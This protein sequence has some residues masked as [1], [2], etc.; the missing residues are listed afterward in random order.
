MHEYMTEVH[1]FQGLRLIESFF[2]Y[3][4]LHYIYILPM[5]FIFLKYLSMRF[6]VYKFD[7]AKSDL[8]RVLFYLVL[9]I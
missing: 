5:T 7:M 9:T 3:N 4:A 8:L 2:F 1:T 6:I